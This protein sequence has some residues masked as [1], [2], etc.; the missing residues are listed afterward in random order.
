MNYPLGVG[1]RFNPLYVR[2]PTYASSA[3]AGRQGDSGKSL[4]STSF[5]QGRRNVFLPLLQ[6]YH[7]AV[8]QSSP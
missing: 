5:R 6:A 3:A 8:N 4:Y 1:L 7:L 2:L